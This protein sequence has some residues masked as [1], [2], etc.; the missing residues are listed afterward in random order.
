MATSEEKIQ[1]LLKK[2]KGAYKGLIMT[3]IEEECPK[4]NQRRR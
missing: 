3:I 2:H 1:E 4:Y